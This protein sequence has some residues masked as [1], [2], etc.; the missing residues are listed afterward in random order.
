M[1]ISVHAENPP[2]KVN[3]SPSLRTAEKP[4]LEEI[5]AVGG[6]VPSSSPYGKFPC[7]L[8]FFPSERYWKVRVCGLLALKL[9]EQIRQSPSRGGREASPLLLLPLPL[10]DLEVLADLADF[11]LLLFGVLADFPLLLFAAFG[12]FG[13]VLLF[14]TGSGAGAGAGATGVDFPAFFADFARKT[15]SSPAFARK[16]ASSPATRVRRVM[17]RMDFANIVGGEKFGGV[18]C[19]GWECVGV[20]WGGV[21][22]GG[23]ECV[24]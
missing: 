17:K 21:C 20:L 14:A 5:A 10:L 8:K 2:V 9:L 6:K 3:S 18:G 11:P 19:W 4:V 7:V 24:L 15:A 13:D 16:T 1:V 22:D 12:V 23:R